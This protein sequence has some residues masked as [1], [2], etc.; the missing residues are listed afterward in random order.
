MHSW[1]QSCQLALWHTTFWPRSV[2]RSVAPAVRTALPSRRGCFMDR[3]RGHSGCGD[4]R[5]RGRVGVVARPL[6][7]GER[8]SPA[9]LCPSG[10]H[11]HVLLRV[12]SV[13]GVGGVNVLVHLALSSY[14]RTYTSPQS[15]RDRTKGAGGDPLEMPSQAMAA[16]RIQNQSR[17][18]PAECEGDCAHGIRL[19]SCVSEEC[20][21]ARPSGVHLDV[22]FCTTKLLRPSARHS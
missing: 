18:E 21:F 17:A 13:P 19:C 22:C 7:L 3:R 9:W 12:Q 2:G 5:S 10:S 1:G 8:G 6:P 16:Q 20:V 14:R 4:W 11:Q 15:I